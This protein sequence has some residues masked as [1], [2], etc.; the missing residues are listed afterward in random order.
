MLDELLGQLVEMQA[1]LQGAVSVVISDGGSDDAFLRLGPLLELNDAISDTMA[2][3][4]D[5][6]A[7]EDSHPP[8]FTGP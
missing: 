1:S 6:Q 3:H 7:R 2:L 8:A 5:A 4:A